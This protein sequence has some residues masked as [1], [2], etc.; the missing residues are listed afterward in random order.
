MGGRRVRYPIHLSTATR[1]KV[2]KR[3]SSPR[4]RFVEAWRR[5]VDPKRAS[6]VADTLR[7]VAGAAAI[8][9]GRLPP[10]SLGVSAERDNV[11]TVRLERPAP[12]F[13][14]LITHS[15]TFPVYSADTAKTHS[16]SKW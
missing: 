6:P 12:Y 4:W 14:Q 3:G 15:A 7:S 10:T 13:P 1:C 9:A 2:V 5:V 11:L 16:P 8:I